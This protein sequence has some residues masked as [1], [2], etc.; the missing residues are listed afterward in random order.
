MACI[1][2]CN[3]DKQVICGAPVASPMN[4]R[5]SF[6]SDFVVEQRA[7]CTPRPPPDPDFEFGIDS[8]SMIDVDRLFFEDWLLPLK[9]PHQRGPRQRVITTLREELRANEEDGARTSNAKKETFLMA[10]MMT[11]VHEQALGFEEEAVY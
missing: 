2:R 6:S 9:D 11:P 1:N 4:P 5:I 8:H 3:L 7:A 10:E